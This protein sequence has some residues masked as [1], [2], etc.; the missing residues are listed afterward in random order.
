LKEEGRYR[1][2]FDINRQKG[3]FPNASFYPIPAT[4]DRSNGAF[5]MSWS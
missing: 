5:C 3:N 4:A 2:F 1:T